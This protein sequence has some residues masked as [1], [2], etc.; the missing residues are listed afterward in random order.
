MN[1]EELLKPFKDASAAW[2]VDLIQIL[3]DYIEESGFYSDTIDFRSV[4]TVLKGSA[5]VFARKVDYIYEFAARVFLNHGTSI[6]TRSRGARRAQPNKDGLSA[7]I[8]DSSTLPDLQSYVTN[9]CGTNPTLVAED[10]LSRK[11]PVPNTCIDIAN[12]D[13]KIIPKQPAT[14]LL[15]GDTDNTLP[16]TTPFY[17]AHKDM[18]TGTLLL[19]TWNTGALIRALGNPIE[20]YF[21]DQLDMSSSESLFKQNKLKHSSTSSPDMLID[22][23]PVC[24]VTPIA[25]SSININGLA[26]P[27]NSK[28]NLLLGAPGI[29]IIEH[30]HDL[31]VAADEDLSIENMMDHDS[32]DNGGRI[33]NLDGSAPDKVLDDLESIENNHNMSQEKSETTHAQVLANKYK[34]FELPINATYKSLID[35]LKST[36]KKNSK[37]HK[38]H[39]KP[40]RTYLDPQTLQAAKDTRLQ[41]IDAHADGFRRRVIK[42]SLGKI[43]SNVISLSYQNTNHIKQSIE[44]Q[45]KKVTVEK[46]QSDNTTHNTGNDLST[47]DEHDDS[48]LKTIS[49][50]IYDPPVSLRQMHSSLEI[51]SIGRDD[52]SKHTSFESIIQKKILELQREAAIYNTSK[53][54]LKWSTYIENMLSDEENRPKFNIELLLEKYRHE[55]AK[56]K[57]QL[58]ALC[59]STQNRYDVVRSFAAILHIASEEDC[60]LS[61]AE[62]GDIIIN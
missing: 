29:D 30:Q 12:V 45:T 42:E 16:T 46:Q 40:R 8:I 22:P 19:E 13:Y 60:L 55:L 20:N 5:N 36:I 31:Q 52:A 41:E 23:V 35:E 6:Q 11:F 38:S 2:E 47:V 44:G 54:T 39:K 32:P 33:N 51:A 7:Q 56:S 57:T 4:A 37:V 9:L 18:L 10:I 58:S 27:R 17:R 53:S 28:G 48:A 26:T 49:N 15:A 62:D 50:G 1:L 3:D 14:V 59:E 61:I 43:C 24:T 21:N 25:L 34:V